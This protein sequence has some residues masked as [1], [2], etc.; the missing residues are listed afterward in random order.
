MCALVETRKLLIL[1]IL[2]H[3]IVLSQDK[4]VSQEVPHF[5]LFMGYFFHVDTKNMKKKV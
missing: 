3:C 4:Y 2:L 1:I 5:I